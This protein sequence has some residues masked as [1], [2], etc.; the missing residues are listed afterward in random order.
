[1]S[2][3]N[4]SIDDSI[5]MSLDVHDGNPVLMW[6]QLADYNTITPAQKST[7]RKFFLNFSIGEERGFGSRLP[8][9][10]ATSRTGVLLQGSARHLMNYG[11]ENF[12]R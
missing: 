6:A 7:A 5:V 11:V 2:L 12:P 3:I 4:Q 1:M 8:L 10:R 9:L